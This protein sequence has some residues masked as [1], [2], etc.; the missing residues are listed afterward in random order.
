M[1]FTGDVTVEVVADGQRPPAVE[2]SRIAK[3]EGSRKQSRV[4]A[5]FEQRQIEA[6]V[7]RQPL[8][9]RLSVGPYGGCAGE[10]VVR[11][12]HDRFP[13]D[14]AAADRAP[15]NQGLD[16]DAGIGEHVQVVQ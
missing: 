12:D 7:D 3:S 9:V 1:V 6:L 2:S 4:A 11:C 10:M 5:A 13:L 15:Q 16:L 14:V 8:G